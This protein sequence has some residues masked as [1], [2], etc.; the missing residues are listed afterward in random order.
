MGYTFS[1]K[2][3]KIQ[4]D[5]E[6]IT[7]LRRLRAFLN[8]KEPELVYILVNTWASQS[9]AITYKELREAIL[10]GDITE[11]HFAE[12]WEDYNRFV[13][14]YLR[15]AWQEAME[16]AVA[17]LKKK[18]PKWYFDPYAEAVQGWCERGAARFVTEITQTQEEGLRAVIQRAATLQDISV[19]TLARTIRPM[20]GLTHPQAVANMRYYETL[21]ANGM[22]EEKAQDLAIRY[23]ARQH[24]Y[25]GYNIA[26]T[27]LAFAYNQGGYEGVKQAQEAGYMGE[28]VKVWSTADDERVCPICGKLEGKRVAM[29]EDFDFTT[30][31]A[32]RPGAETIMKVPPAHP[33]CRCAVKYVE[34]AP[35]PRRQE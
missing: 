1:K 19:D 35:P 6:S 4:K 11:D 32:G 27:E 22:K 8:R 24:R 15:P 33:G 20:V 7:A 21:L 14:M 18:Y 10:A 25:R 23:A 29:E 17:S 34:I 26:R 16:A 3:I 12:W 30:Q 9:K 2:Q 28:V 13:V 31:L 5:A